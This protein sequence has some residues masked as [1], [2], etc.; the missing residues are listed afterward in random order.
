MLY[1]A[2]GCKWP[3]LTQSY[4][5]PDPPTIVVREDSFATGIQQQV[6][7]I[8]NNFKYNLAKLEPARV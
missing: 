2:R 8:E 3:F 6:K 5:F 7:L 1:I 4:I